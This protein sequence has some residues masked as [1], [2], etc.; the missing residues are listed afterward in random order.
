MMSGRC[1]VSDG[2]GLDTP[3]ETRNAIMRQVMR[4]V[5]GLI[6]FQSTTLL[7]ILGAEVE[8]EYEW[9]PPHLEAGLILPVRTPQQASPSE[10]T[11][12]L[13]ASPAASEAEPT[14]AAT[15]KQAADTEAGDDPAP[16][17]NAATRGQSA[18]EASKGEVDAEK[19][20]DSP[21]ETDSEFPTQ[22]IDLENE[23]STMTA[24]WDVETDQETLPKTAER[25]T[26][27]TASM[28]ARAWARQ[29]APEPRYA[30][31]TPAQRE[32]ELERLNKIIADYR[33]MNQRA[34][35]LGAYQ[36]RIVL[37]CSPL[38]RFV[39]TYC[40]KWSLKYGA[41]LFPSAAWGLTVPLRRQCRLWSR[42][43]WVELCRVWDVG[44]AMQV[45]H[46]EI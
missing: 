42:N 45:L 4:E 19:S 15:P 12:P 39:G 32:E 21:T 46:R 40:E 34:A 17:T 24:E 22:A 8:P 38:S 33:G 6:H 30:K 43:S 29:C 11:T 16:T 35:A 20:G 3:E 2:V 28:E 13:E 9:I 1:K 31:L 37:L 44:F 14:Q 26:T 10:E 41:C 5:L 7:N 27:L 36:H 25:A 23:T 18:S